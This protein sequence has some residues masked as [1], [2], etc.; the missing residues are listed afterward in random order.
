MTDNDE[1]SEPEVVLASPTKTFFVHMLTRDIELKDAILD[2]L[3]NCIDGVLRRINAKK[4]KSSTPYKDYWAKIT[5]NPNEFI[6]EDNCGGIPRE[7]A[8][9]SAFMMGRLDGERDAKLE[10][11]GMYGIGMK[12]AI[13]KMGQNC[14]VNS[15]PVGESAFDVAITAAWM[16]KEGPDAW[17][18][19]ITDAKKRSTDGTKIHVTRLR[20]EIKKQFNANKG[21]F[22][23]DLC[24]EISNLFAVIMEKGFSIKVNGTTVKPVPL[25]L[26]IP[27]RIG[28]GDRIEPYVFTGDYKGVSIEIVAGFYRPLATEQEIDEEL[29][30]RRKKS[31]AGWTVIC[32]DRVVL[33]H[34]TSIQ[35]GWGTTGVAS[36]HNQFIAIAG[37]ATFRSNESE[38]L[39]LNTTKR[40]LDMNSP[41]YSIALD[42]MKRGLKKLIKYT[43]DWKKRIDE[44]AAQFQELEPVKATEVS[45]RV[46]PSKFST[47]RKHTAMGT[48]KYYEPS[49]PKPKVQKTTKRISYIAPIKDIE[50]L[51]DYFYEDKKANHN[52][53]GKR[54][55]DECVV[56]AKEE[57][58]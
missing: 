31:N 42:H 19:P 52:E 55:F 35:T 29:T 46:S 56:E 41:V 39:P 23:E 26:M 18:L 9:N 44:T 4:R 6:I 30:R 37:I 25:T 51:G 28:R 22:E 40:G 21:N 50:L 36:Y 8:I 16:K 54:C 24:R 12:R 1:P 33:S 17:T 58:E 27:K 2:L 11:I 53:I 10:T 20:P 43:N 45:K 38:H 13:F 47:S 48:G 34:D 7:I 49:L 3:D 14:V 57:L 15:Q 5:L 32:N